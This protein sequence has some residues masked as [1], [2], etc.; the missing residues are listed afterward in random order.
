MNITFVLELKDLD[1]AL[2]RF[3]L[4]Q[5]QTGFQRLRFLIFFICIDR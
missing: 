4:N 5:V 3:I 1:A 2:G